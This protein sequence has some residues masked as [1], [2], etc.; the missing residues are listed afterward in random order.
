MSK[1]NPA[2]EPSILKYIRGNQSKER[3]ETFNKQVT[4]LRQALGYRNRQ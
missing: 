3:A 4:Q 2:T 1:R